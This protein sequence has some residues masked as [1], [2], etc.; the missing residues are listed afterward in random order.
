[1]RVRCRSVALLLSDEKFPPV[2]CLH[3]YAELSGSC[4]D[5]LPGLV[6]LPVRDPFDLIEARNHIAH[7]G[8]INKGFLALFR[9]GE[10]A[11]GEPIFFCGAEPRGAGHVGI[12]TLTARCLSSALQI[13][14]GCFFLLFGC[15]VLVLPRRRRA[16]RLGQATVRGARFRRLT[17]ASPNVGRVGHTGRFRTGPDRVRKRRSEATPIARR[18]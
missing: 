12:S 4:S 15:H 3:C 1:M 7:V 2:V 5:A 8:S 16:K 17:W 11:L 10:L 13:S 14:P 9:K 6:P 18:T